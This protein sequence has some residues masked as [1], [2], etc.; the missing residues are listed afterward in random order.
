LEEEESSEEVKS[1]LPLCGGP[2]RWRTMHLRTADN[3]AGRRGGIR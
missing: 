3:M 1:F 2:A